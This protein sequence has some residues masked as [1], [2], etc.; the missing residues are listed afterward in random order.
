VRDERAGL[1][2]LD[3]LPHVLVEVGEGLGGP[4]G[5]I[6]VSSWIERL[7]SSSVK[8]SMPQSVWWIRIISRV[9]SSRWLIASERIS[10]SVTTPP[11]LRITCASPSCRPRIA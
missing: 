3:R 1:D 4:P 5:L 8:V 10:S 2:P 9:P 11:A 6:P 7:N